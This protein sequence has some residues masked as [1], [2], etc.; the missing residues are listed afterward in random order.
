MDGSVVA[1]LSPLEAANQRLYALREQARIQCECQAHER[2]LAVPLNQLR[3]VENPNSWKTA[4]D[5]ER[6]LVNQPVT[7]DGGPRP[8]LPPHLGWGSERVT[9]VLRGYLASA[10]NLAEEGSP[11]TAV[12]MSTAGAD[13][14]VLA[15]PG[16]VTQPKAEAPSAVGWVKLYPDIGLGMLRE[17]LTAPG[18][19]WLMLRY[20]DG[21]GQGSFRIDMVSDYLTPKSASLH[22]CGRRQLRN[23]LRDGDG[24]FWTRDKE[25]IWLRSA[26]RV[27]YALGVPRLTGQPVALPVAGLLTGV[28][29]FRAHLYAAFHSGRTRE[30]KQGVWSRPIARETMTQLSGVGRSSQRVYEERLGLMVQAN[31]AVGEPSDKENLEQRAWVQGQS[32]FELKDYYGQQGKKGKVYLA[33]QLPNS[34]VGQHKRRPKGRQKRIN[35][36]L[37]DLVMK[38]MPGNVGVAVETQSSDRIAVKRYYANGKLAAQ[39]YGRRASHEQHSLYWQRHGTR[40][41][42][43]VLWQ[44]LG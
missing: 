8:K 2:R 40:N 44:E 29:A 42:R 9:A 19:L 43:F 25:H 10:A 27:A 23:L 20:L 36:K 7:G 3:E 30:T 22:L 39:A 6:A 17:E 15:Q 4:V 13:R 18:R 26:E 16:P 5:Q 21:V 37:K 14:L 41:G 12:Q 1:P 33:W 34:Y 28:G 24:V 35:R 31:F 11:E 38:G 32:L